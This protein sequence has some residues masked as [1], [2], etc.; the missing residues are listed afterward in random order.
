MDTDRFVADLA[1]TVT[2][3]LSEDWKASKGPT[4]LALAKEKYSTLAQAL[5]KNNLSF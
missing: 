4:A 2:R 3:S 1:R 5:D